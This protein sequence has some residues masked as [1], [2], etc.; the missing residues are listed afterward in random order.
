MKK[1]FR[2]KKGLPIFIVPLI[3][4][5]IALTSVVGIFRVIRTPEIGGFSIPIYIW[6]FGLLLLILLIRR[7]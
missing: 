5:G 3:Y 6:V 4:L 2:N 1:L 7:R